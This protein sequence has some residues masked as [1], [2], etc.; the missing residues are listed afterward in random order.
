MK[1]WINIL[2]S[3]LILIAL[4]ACE[5]SALN[6]IHDDMLEEWIDQQL[7]ISLH[8]SKKS[9]VLRFSKVDDVDIPPYGVH[10]GSGRELSNTP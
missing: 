8:E 6:Q 2:L 4:S 7:G 3:F 1:R 10:K 9:S 5:S